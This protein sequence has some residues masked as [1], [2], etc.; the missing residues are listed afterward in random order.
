MPEIIR[1]EMIS[2]HHDN[3]LAGYFGINKTR[4][5]VARKYYWKTLFHNVKSY[6]QGCDIYLASKVVKHKRS[7]NLQSLPIPTYYWKDLLIDFVTGLSNSI[8]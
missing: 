4:K 5:L 7:D 6:M 1:T 2:Q 8:D 3:L